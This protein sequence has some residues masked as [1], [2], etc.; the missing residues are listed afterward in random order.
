GGL[1]GCGHLP[2]TGQVVGVALRR[3]HQGPAPGVLRPGPLAADAGAAEQPQLPAAVPPALNRQGAEEP[4]HPLPGGAAQPPPTPPPA[5]PPRR[6]TA[7]LVRS[8]LCGPLP[9]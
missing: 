4:Y 5:R 8:L 1:L 6:R 3:L 7:S 2:R 9:P